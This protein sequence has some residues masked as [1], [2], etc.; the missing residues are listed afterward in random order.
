MKNKYKS[1]LILKLLPLLIL[2]VVV[3]IGSMIPMIF[4]QKAIDILPQQNFLKFTYYILAYIGIYIITQ[5]LR[6][7]INKKVKFFEID[8]VGNFK[9]K[10]CK[11]ILN[12]DLKLLENEGGNSLTQKL[13]EDFS[14]IENRFSNILLEI[15]FSFASAI[16]GIIIFAIYD[17]ILVTILIPISLITTF[18]I[19]K[20]YKK[21]EKYSSL[22]QIE[23]TKTNNMFRYIITGARDIILYGK[24]KIFYQD[25]NAE[26]NKLNMTEKQ[27]IG[28]QII[29]QNSISLSF[30]ILIGILILIGGYRINSGKLTTGALVTII[31]YNSM[32]TD[33]IFNFIDNQKELFDV[34]TA[35]KRIS[36]IYNNSLKEMEIKEL[37]ELDKIELVNIKLK[38]DNTEILNNF[39]LII[40]KG[41]IIKINGKTGTGKSSI[42]KIITGLY[43]P[44]E[45]KILINNSSL[46]KCAI[47]SVF[48]NNTLFDCSIE[49][50][51][52][53]F[54][55]VKEEDYLKVVEITH[56]NDILKKYKDKN[57]GE[58]GN[59]LSGGEKTRILVCRALLQKNADLF[60]FDEISTGLDKCIFQDMVEK[61]IDYLEGKTIIFIDHS[62]MDSKYFN[63][64]I[65]L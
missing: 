1:K 28:I 59:K 2:N 55:T 47:S 43:T 44:T 9:I 41:D 54:D 65:Y 16:V 19:N 48:Q 27:N 25:F 56:T 53:F 58:D 29:S 3:G 50:N 8:S 12:T 38:Y 30:N 21:T 46:K 23:H 51:I 35:I 7:Y 11:K 39:N 20:S 4:I 6:S 62:E 22:S 26:I 17:V 60:I 49:E 31:M 57:I 61:I 64:N 5:I 24:E 32:V 15:T 13:I 33:P 52:K 10:F 18:V 34:S 42:A 36:N 37:V 63:K 45:G 40:N 14:M